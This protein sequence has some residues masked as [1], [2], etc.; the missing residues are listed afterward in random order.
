MLKISQ[1]NLGGNSVSNKTVNRLA[2][3]L[4]F[5]HEIQRDKGKLMI[6]DAMMPSRLKIT[7][8]LKIQ[9]NS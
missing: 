3:A 4:L 8:S 6:L 2:A 5:R 7:P 1:E 9:R